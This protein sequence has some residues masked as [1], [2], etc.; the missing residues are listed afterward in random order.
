MTLRRLGREGLLPEGVGVRVELRRS[1][2]PNLRLVLKLGLLARECS[3]VPLRQL[4][5]LLLLLSL[6]EWLLGHRLSPSPFPWFLLLHELLLIGKPILVHQE[7]LLLLHLLHMLHMHPHLPLFL[8]L[9][10][11]KLVQ[12]VLVHRQDLVQVP[13]DEPLKEILRNRH[14]WRSL[15]FSL[16]HLRGIS[17][18]SR[19]ILVG[20]FRLVEDASGAAPRTLVVLRRA[21]GRGVIAEG[22]V[23][24]FPAIRGDPLI[25][26]LGL[27]RS[28][29]SFSSNEGMFHCHVWSPSR[30]WVDSQE[31]FHE[32]NESLNCPKL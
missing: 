16:L 20:E 10:V 18:T 23:T 17:S 25:L 13:E 31:A 2:P 14:D 11:Y 24:S 26:L 29:V 22:F 32:I 1:V 15:R 7:L 8:P 5:L 9:L 28:V 4:E 30:A 12:L 3:L 21:R 6:H 19:S 27:I